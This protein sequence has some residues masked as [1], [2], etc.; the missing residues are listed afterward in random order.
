MAA[1]IGS[2]HRDIVL[3]SDEAAARIPAL[4]SSLDQPLADAAVVPLHSVA[5]FARNEVTVAIGGEGADELFGGYPRYAWLGCAP[6]GLGWNGH[7]SAIGNRI[8]RATSTSRRIRRA[9]DLAVPRPVTERHLDWVTA[10]RRH[11]RS[12]LY[13]ARLLEALDRDRMVADL[14]RDIEESRS[15][16]M[17]GSL[18]RLDQ[19]H[20]LP[21]DVLVKADRA[22]MLASLELRTPYL[23][24]ELAEFATSVAP[25]THLSGGGKQLLRLLLSQ[26][27]PDAPRRRK[28]A[29]LPPIA[30]W[31]RGTLGPV[32][33]D[34]VA[35][36]SLYAEGWMRSD[37]ASQL[38]SEH[39]RGQADRSHIL[40][41]LLA[42][43]LWLDR[44]RGVDSA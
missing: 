32:M 15:Y 3:G 1:L 42:A 28:V 16:S 40:W 35:R 11:E 8:P 18:M 26:L 17:S 20:W 34:Q 14:E 24:R 33:E 12:G 6:Q 9:L 39:R 37:V 25:S 7:A 30:D 36:G 19:L 31:L 10:G 29:F 44:F 5:E 2:E 13:G 27:L 38:L 23:Q 22:G 4:L 41:P 21:D 43:G